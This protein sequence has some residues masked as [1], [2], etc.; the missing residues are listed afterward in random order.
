VGLVNDTD[1]R[2]SLAD[3][4]DPQVVDDLIAPGGYTQIAYAGAPPATKSAALPGLPAVL[5]WPGTKDEAHYGGDLREVTLPFVVRFYLAEI[6]TSEDTLAGTLDAL[7][8]WRTVLRDQTLKHLQLSPAA[9]QYVVEART[10]STHMAR[11]GYGGKTYAGVEL[12]V[13]VV[14]VEGIS[15]TP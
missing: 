10:N 15:A 6:G 13:D 3:I 2:D 11:L 7:W 5:V 1:I 8:A 12:E 14:V 4:Y 9:L